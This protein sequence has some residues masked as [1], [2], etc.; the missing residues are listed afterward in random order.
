M[1]LARPY[2]IATAAFA[3]ASE[4]VVAG[5]RERRAPAP[6]RPI[7]SAA[8]TSTPRWCGAYGPSRRAAFSSWRSQP[9]R[10]PRPAWY[11]ATATWTS[12]CRK[13]RSSGGA[14][15]HSSSS[16]SCAAKNSPAAIS[17]RPCSS[18]TRSGAGGLGRLAVLFVSFDSA[19]TFVW[20]TVAT[21]VPTR[22]ATVERGRRARRER[23]HGERSDRSPT[24]I[25]RI[26]DDAGRSV[27]AVPDDDRVLRERGHVQVRERRR[28]R[29]RGRDD[30][31]AEASPADPRCRPHRGRGLQ[32]SACRL[33]VTGTTRGSRSAAYAPPS[34]EHSKATPGSLAVKAK[35]A[36]VSVVE[37]GGVEA[38]VTVGAVVSGWT[39]RHC[40]ASPASP[41]S[42]PC[43]SRGP[44]TCGYRGRDRRDTRGWCTR[45][46]RRHRACRRTSHRPRWT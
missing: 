26:D 15:R 38:S 16:S 1:A 42:R 23:R 5:R 31:P 17:S 7:A 19:T 36:L 25:L 11:Q 40:D 33:R 22:Q 37:A 13:S 41:R 8:A 10:F 46:R 34:S 14:S 12:P 27:P 18:P 3:R 44:R 9:G 2:K 35:L 30:R 20:S 29:R 39:Y 32:R 21:Y 4:Q 24:V 43:P 45:S 28:W 6:R